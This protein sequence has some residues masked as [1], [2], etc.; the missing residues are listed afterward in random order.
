MS[1]A[2]KRQNGKSETLTEFVAQIVAQIKPS[3]Q[4]AAPGSN[5]SATLSPALQNDQ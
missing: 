3:V 1:I 2:E 4:R 5:T